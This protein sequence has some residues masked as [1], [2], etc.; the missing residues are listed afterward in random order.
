M[1]SIPAKLVTIITVFEAREHVQTALRDFGLGGYSVA[2]VE[3]HG[4]HG[5]LAS[6]IGSAKNFLFLVLTDAARASRLLAWVEGELLPSFPGV[7]Y[8]VDAVAVPESVV[9]RSTAKA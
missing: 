4:V 6:S 7:A 5:D 2:R 1:P 8:A 3:G 9:T